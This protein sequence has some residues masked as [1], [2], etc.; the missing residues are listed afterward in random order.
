[1]TRIQWESCNSKCYCGINITD[2][3]SVTYNDRT[4][5]VVSN[6]NNLRWTHTSTKNGVIIDFI[7]TT[8]MNRASLGPARDLSTTTSRQHSGASVGQ[9]ATY[10]LTKE[11]TNCGTYGS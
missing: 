6:V 4:S 5:R 8:T 1:H 10:M 3:L 11:A 7:V 2:I 9:P